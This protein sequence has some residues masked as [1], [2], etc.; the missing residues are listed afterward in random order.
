VTIIGHPIP[1]V[2]GLPFDLELGNHAVERLIERM[3]VLD[4]AAIRNEFA[5]LALSC[6]IA[7]DAPDGEYQARTANG[8]APVHKRGPE[9]IVATWIPMEGHNRRWSGDWMQFQAGAGVRFEVAGNAPVYALRK[10]LD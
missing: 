10:L 8:F 5:P 7:N 4:Q 6:L 3:G 9:F 1:K 2:H